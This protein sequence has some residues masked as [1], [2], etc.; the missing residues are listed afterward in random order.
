DLDRAGP[1]AVIGT[2]PSEVSNSRAGDHRLGW[3]AAFV[4][5]RATNMLAFNQRRFV[6]GARQCG[7]E[8]TA[9]LAGAYDDGVVVGST[10]ELPSAGAVAGVCASNEAMSAVQPVWW[11]A[12]TPRPVS[13]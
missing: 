6:A 7:A 3:R 8:R 4:D 2:P 1:D 13:P 11:L 9:G 10:H 12:P 5:A